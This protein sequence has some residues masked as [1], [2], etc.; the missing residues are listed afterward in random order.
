MYGKEQLIIC[1]GKINFGSNM[2]IWKNLLENMLR[3]EIYLQG[4]WNGY[5]DKKL[6]CHL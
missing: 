6:G 1:Q 5:P 3:L 4:G 2:H